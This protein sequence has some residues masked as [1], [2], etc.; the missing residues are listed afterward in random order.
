MSQEQQQLDSWSR[1]SSVFSHFK[2]CLTILKEKI[3]LPPL[4]KRGEGGRPVARPCT[5][6]VVFPPAIGG[7]KRGQSLILYYI[8][9][10]MLF[11]HVAQTPS[12]YLFWFDYCVAAI[13]LH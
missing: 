1:L 8:H 12:T 5:F 2:L 11:L 10:W 7:A 3:T 6:S 13:S 9:R 4:Q